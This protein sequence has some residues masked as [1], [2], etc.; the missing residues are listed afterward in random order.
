MII[1]A[2][3]PLSASAEDVAANQSSTPGITEGA[4]NLQSVSGN[5]VVSD[6]MSFDEMVS[7]ISSDKGISIDQASDLIRSNSG[8]TRSLSSARLATYRTFTQQIPNSGQYFKPSVSF[9]C[10]TTEGGGYG[11]ILKILTTNLIRSYDIYTLQ[12]SG[13][14]YVNLENGSKIHYVL[15][16]DW[17]ENGVTSQTGSIGISIGEF[18]TASYSVTSS[19][20]HYRYQYAESDLTWGHVR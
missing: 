3:V 10:E 8:V 6:V 7:R 15:N 1:G 9:Y 17:Y 20:H 5:T 14:L 12:F 19:N 18:F 2:S 13:S 16:G 11:A 4:I